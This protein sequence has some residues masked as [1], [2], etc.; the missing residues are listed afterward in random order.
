MLSEQPKTFLTERQRRDLLQDVYEYLKFLKLD[1]SASTL[2]SESG[3]SLCT[4]SG[5]TCTSA[6]LET[7]WLS[8]LK[9]QKRV[10]DLEHKCQE[11]SRE[12]LLEPDSQKNFLLDPVATVPHINNF[13]DHFLSAQY[14]DRGIS[15]IAVTEK[16]LY[17]ASESGTV[18]QWKLCNDRYELQERTVGH[19]A[20]VTSMAHY[21]GSPEML[22]TC[23]SDLCIKIWHSSLETGRLC[24][25]KTLKGHS[26]VVSS[27]CFAPSGRWLYSAGRDKLIKV[28]NTDTGYCVSTAKGHTQWIKTL[29]VSPDGS[30]LA[31]AGMDQCVRLWS[32]SSANPIVEPKA[33]LAGHMHVIEQVSFAPERQDLLVSC[34]RDNSVRIWNTAT[35]SLLITLTEHTNWVRSI[36][37]KGHH[38]VSVSDDG[39][40][41]LWD[42]SGKCLQSVASPRSAFMTAIHPSNKENFFV[43]YNDGYLT[44]I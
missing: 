6:A 20:G 35:E 33:A 34:A 23:S 24:V 26:N 41:K 7:K 18:S 19:A 13:A 5:G 9:L 37:F 1:A 16:F 2:L 15:G 25:N 4:T 10:F 21:A 28:W 27:I 17:L 36:A 31:S 3:L 40:I 14:E 8:V 42:C 39:K 30:L 11:L 12:T 43:G 32:L 44:V 22:A 38:F 29:D